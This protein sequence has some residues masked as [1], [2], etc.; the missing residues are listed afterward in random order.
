VIDTAVAEGER[1]FAVDGQKYTI[2]LCIMHTSE[3][4]NVMGPFTE[5]GR[6]TGSTRVSRS[7]S[8][9]RP[10]RS[11]TSAGSPREIREWARANG[12]AQVSG[13]GR[14]P[15]EILAAYQAAHGGAAG[16][17]DGQAAASAA[18]AASSGGGEVT[19][20]PAGTGRRAR[21]STGAPRPRRARKAAS[22]RKAAPEG[23]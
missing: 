8:R 11:G 17:S 9:R 16:P 2:D 18:L 21:K 6:S 15:G 20:A 10:S 3:F 12:F 14:V 4:D 19:T 1:A 22:A 7:S 23:E 5:A 13:R